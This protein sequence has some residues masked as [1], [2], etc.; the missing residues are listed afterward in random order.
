MADNVFTSIPQT[1]MLPGRQ[2]FNN[3]LF[4]PPPAQGLFAQIELMP[5]Q[6]AQIVLSSA[7][8]TSRV[9]TDL[10]QDAQAETERLTDLGIKP[11]LSYRPQIPE[12]A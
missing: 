12:N 5:P 6:I 10:S 9:A 2:S 8:A 7:E 1:N 4:A 3:P 11:R